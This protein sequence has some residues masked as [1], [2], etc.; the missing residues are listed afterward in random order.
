MTNHGDDC[1][2]FYYSTCTKGDSC[3][4]RHCEAAIGNETVCNLWQE[5]RCHRAI[6]K[7]RHMEITHN[8]KEIL[9]YWE[10]QPAGCQ[11]PHCAFFHEKPRYI[12]GLYVPPDKSVKKKEEVP[13]EE[14]APP[15]AALPTAANPQ[16]R[17]II[18]SE[19]QEPVSSPTHP[20]VVINPA[21]DDEDEDDQ[22]SEEGELGVSPRKLPKADD[23]LNFGVSTLEEIRLRRALK[24]SIKKT[25]HSFP[26]GDTSSNG[27]KENIQSFHRPARDAAGIRSGDELPLRRSLAERLGGVVGEEQP[28][29]PFHK[30]SKSVK[31]RLS[32]PPELSASPQS[33]ETSPKLKKPEQIHIK[34]LEEIKQ[35]KAAKSQTQKVCSASEITKAI[36]PKIPKGVKIAIPFKDNPISHVKTFSENLHAKKKRQKEDQEH[37]SS[38]KKT[39]HNNETSVAETQDKADSAGSQ[40]DTSEGEIR[41]KTLEEIRREKAARHQAQ[42]V[43]ELQKTSPDPQETSAR[44]PHLLCLKKS[45]SQSKVTTQKSEDVTEKHLNPA[46]ANETSG[47]SK[48]IKVKTFEEIM[49]EKRLRKKEMEEQVSSCQAKNSANIELPLQQTTNS[50]TLKRKV[51]AKI[52]FYADSSETA[53]TTN[54]VVSK[55]IP[56]TSK[57]SSPPT[58][59]P[60]SPTVIAASVKYDEAYSHRPSSRDTTSAPSVKPHN[61]VQKTHEPT[62]DTKVRPKLNVKPSVVKPA[63]QL[64]PGQKRNALERSAVA[65][66]KPLN[67]TST[68]TPVETA[69]TDSR[70][71][72]SLCQDTPLNNAVHSNP[73]TLSAADTCTVPQSQV[74]KTPT[75]PKSRRPSVA[76]S[77]STSSSATSSSAVYDFEELISEFTT[78][79]HLEEDPGLGE[80][81]LLQELS[82]MID[83]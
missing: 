37:T 2:F 31:E 9:C 39:K 51:P 83:S 22:F 6:C 33:V 81:D 21:D 58:S 73:A 63:V 38:P 47:S 50:P 64:K 68:E 3:P 11:K 36:T 28:S 10:N 16:L 13:Q 8:R 65:A 79:E 59:N 74:Q 30:S 5:G 32:L 61:N 76:V 57:A 19:S 66:V 44:K 42:Q 56:L 26:G 70:V 55:A 24:A 14:P 20:P 77:R 34:T 49:R 53:A 17:G 48:G 46:A 82:D 69:C 75:Q 23:S 54:A 29:A 41:V 25:M 1:Y 12:D 80:E 67:S 7:F 18:K 62:A 27:E 45:A 43:Q 60:S 52:T 15:Q 72:P 35:E 71:F 4:F 40:E 78:D